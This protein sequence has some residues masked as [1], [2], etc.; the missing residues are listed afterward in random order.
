MGQPF[1]VGEHLTYLVV[2]CRE[3][4]PPRIQG[5][6]LLTQ[7]LAAKMMGHH[8]ACDTLKSVHSRCSKSSNA[9]RCIAVLALRGYGLH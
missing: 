1:L 6:W 8:L 9:I 4:A 7:K 2:S 5:A 3:I